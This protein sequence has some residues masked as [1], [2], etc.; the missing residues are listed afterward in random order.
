MVLSCLIDEEERL[1]DLGVLRLIEFA[2]WRSLSKYCSFEMTLHAF[3]VIDYI[4]QIIFLCQFFLAKE[5]SMLVW[6]KET[7]LT[8]LF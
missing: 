5:Q 7:L 3:Q 6:L 8:Y 4:I 2:G 1:L